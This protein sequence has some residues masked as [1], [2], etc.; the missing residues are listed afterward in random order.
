MSRIAFALVAALVAAAPLAAQMEPV[1]PTGTI[2]RP[3]GLEGFKPL[4]VTLTEGGA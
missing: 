4:T 3:V 1:L 2:D